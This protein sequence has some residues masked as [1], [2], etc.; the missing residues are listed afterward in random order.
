MALRNFINAVKKKN[1]IVLSKKS[2]RGNKPFFVIPAL[3]PCEVVGV[4]AD[5]NQIAVVL[6]LNNLKSRIVIF[7]TKQKKIVQDE[8]WWIWATGYS[9]IKHIAFVDGVLLLQ[10]TAD[11]FEINSQITSKQVFLAA[12]FPSGIIEVVDSRGIRLEQSEGFKGYFY[13]SPKITAEG[14]KTSKGKVF[15]Q[16]KVVYGKQSQVF[17]VPVEAE[18]FIT[19]KLALKA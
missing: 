12:R 18:T 9:W 2:K 15:H 17:E 13:R 14:I 19:P 7:D 3:Q 8:E 16:F 4:A 11:F 6:K 10:G 1:E 5:K